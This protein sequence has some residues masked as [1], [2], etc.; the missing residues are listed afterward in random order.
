MIRNK[1][2]CT[3]ATNLRGGKGT[4]VIENFL[5]ADEML[6]HGRGFGR[7]VFKPGVSIGPHRHVDE[8]EL[9]YVISGEGTYTSGGKTEPIKAGECAM[10]NV[11]E[12]HAIEN[13]SKDQDME[14]LFLMI[15]GEGKTEGHAEAVEA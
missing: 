11:G 6:G 13:T 1:Y 7:I 8:F 2:A 5:T 14:V 4:L 10:L 3:E 15:N 9:F 12:T